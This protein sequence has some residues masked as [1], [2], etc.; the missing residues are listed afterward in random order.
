MLAYEDDVVLLAPSRSPSAAAGYIGKHINTID[1]T[2]N[3]KKSVCTIFRPRQSS[4]VASLCFPCRLGCNVLQNHGVAHCKTVP[5]L[6]SNRGRLTSK[7]QRT[8]NTK[9]YGK[10]SAVRCVS[11]TSFSA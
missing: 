7:T 1:L 8:V 9:V 3:V 6:H 4:R 11:E 2:R 10:R 5:D